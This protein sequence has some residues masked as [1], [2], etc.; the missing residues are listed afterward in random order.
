[1]DRRSEPGWNARVWRGR[2]L[3]SEAT[4]P[5]LFPETPLEGTPWLDPWREQE[6]R[7]V[8]VTCRVLFALSALAFV[9][10]WFLVD[11]PLRLEPAA[12]W[13]TYRFAS[14]APYAA[15]TAVTFLP[16]FR[17]PPAAERTMIG[18]TLVLGSMQAKTVEW[19]PWVAPG[20]AFALTVSSLIMARR[21]WTT[22]AWGSRWR[23]STGC[24]TGS[25][26]CRDRRRGA[27]A[28]GSGSRS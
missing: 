22:T 15:L 16:G 7:V 21:T 28:R 1:V 17:R 26:R 11:G 6:A 27:A 2:R 24:S 25:T 10:H 3:L 19:A 23:S 8:V 5:A 4:V 13:A 14:A 9:A 20:W 18:F 12:R